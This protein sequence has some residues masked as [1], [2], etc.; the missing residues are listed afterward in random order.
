[1]ELAAR[2]R[3]YS[4]PETAALPLRRFRGQCAEFAFDEFLRTTTT[5]RRTNGGGAS[6]PV[7]RPECRLVSRFLLSVFSLSDR[8]PVSDIGMMFAVHEEQEV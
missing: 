3:L 5:R 8:L 4:Q 7:S 6:T 2:R 1:M